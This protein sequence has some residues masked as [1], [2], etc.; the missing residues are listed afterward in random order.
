MLDRGLFIIH[1]IIIM[2]ICKAQKKVFSFW[3]P[4]ASPQTR[5]SAFLIEF[6]F[7]FLAMKRCPIAAQPILLDRL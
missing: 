6:V 1:L 3:S 2:N 4:H 5:A 7:C